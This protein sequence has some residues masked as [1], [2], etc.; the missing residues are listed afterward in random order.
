[1]VCGWWDPGAAPRPPTVPFI[2]VEE[3]K[4]RAAARFQRTIAPWLEKYP[5]V[6]T[7]TSFVAEP[8]REALIRAAAG[9]TLLVVGDRGVGSAPELLLGPVAQAMLHHAPCSVAITHAPGAS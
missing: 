5:Q 2:D 9:A 6:E 8:P 1:M 7:K 3:L 4:R